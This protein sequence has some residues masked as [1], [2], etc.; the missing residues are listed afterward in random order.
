MKEM[1][2]LNACNIILLCIM[3]VHVDTSLLISDPCTGVSV[4]T[5]AEQERSKKHLCL[6]TGASQADLGEHGK[7]EMVACNTCTCQFTI[8]F[9]SMCW[10]LCPQAEQERSEGSIWSL[11]STSS[12]KNLKVVML[13]ACNTCGHLKYRNGRLQ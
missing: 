2:M 4:A 12:L 1:V 3:H 7:K 5:Q 10:C 6:D 13:N 11:V 9:R 8:V